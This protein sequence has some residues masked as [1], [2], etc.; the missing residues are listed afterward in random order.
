M[1]RLY[2]DGKEIPHTEGRVVQESSH[3]QIEA[4]KF[5]GMDS[6]AVKHQGSL[7][8]RLEGHE[9]PF[10]MDIPLRIGLG[11]RVVVYSLDLYDDIRLKHFPELVIKDQPNYREENLSSLE[12]FFDRDKIEKRI[13]LL[14]KIEKKDLLPEN[15]PYDNFELIK[16]PPLEKLNQL[17]SSLEP[18]FPEEKLNLISL[19][20][21][22]GK[23]VSILGFQVLDEQGNVIVQYALPIVG[24]GYR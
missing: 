5:L 2:L 18:R 21:F 1:E 10:R 15:E 23:S 3:E 14:E 20:E 24:L 11:A 7:E 9:E 17:E 12:E 8:F 22:L 19:K 6:Y 4:K 13:P 16:D